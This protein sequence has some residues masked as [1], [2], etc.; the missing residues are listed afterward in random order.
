MIYGKRDLQ[1]HQCFSCTF[2][3]TGIFLERHNLLLSRGHIFCAVDSLVHRWC[4]DNL[5][6]RFQTE[7]LGFLLLWS[8]IYCLSIEML[9]SQL[10]SCKAS[11]WILLLPEWYSPGDQ[12]SLVPSHP[13][14]HSHPPSHL[15]QLPEAQAR[16]LHFSKG[17][18]NSHW[19]CFPQTSCAGIK[20]IH[21]PPRVSL[22]V[23]V[24]TG[25]KLRRS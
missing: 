3:N 24:K 23:S 17:S 12:T 1:T 15:L 9:I 2:P 13:L 18:G 6:S 7:D 10:T 21:A 8:L 20:W 19:H 4:S 11:W 25:G 5:G 14:H 16:P 22:W